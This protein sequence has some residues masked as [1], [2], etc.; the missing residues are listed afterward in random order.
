MGSTIT[1][2]VS[3]EKMTMAATIGKPFK[4]NVNHS[5]LWFDSFT[6]KYI[7]SF[8]ILPTITTAKEG[9]SVTFTC[10]VTG[11]GIKI[12]EWYRNKKRVSSTLQNF[13]DMYISTL[14]LSPVTSSQ[15][16]LF[17]CRTTF[18]YGSNLYKA[19]KAKSGLLSVTGR[20]VMLCTCSKINYIVYGEV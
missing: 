1:H 5:N 14:Q 17:E 7:S 3:K 20:E 6:G 19:Y 4:R 16:G 18:A 8:S 9:G 13:N 2:I 10:N 11:K 12:V 15:S